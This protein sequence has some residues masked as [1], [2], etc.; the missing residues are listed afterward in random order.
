M[1]LTERL[2]LIVSLDA[3]GAVQGLS[4]VGNAAEKELGKTENRL[5]RVGKSMSKTGVVML[6]AGAV[7]GGAL[8]KA[9]LA[10]ERAEASTRKLQNS[11][12]NSAQLAGHS[13]DEF[14]D[15]AAAIQKKTAAD[16]DDIVAGQAILAQ[17]KLEADEIKTLTPLVVDLARKK[18]IDLTAASTAVAKAMA[19]QSGALKKAGVIVDE[20]A[21][22]TDRFTAI[23]TAL[24]DSVGGFAEEEGKTFAGSLERLKNQ[25]EDISEGV[26]KGAVDAFSSMLRPVQGLS[27][28]FAGLDPKVQS[29]VGKIGT[30]G[31]AGLIVVGAT[32][33]IVG[34]VLTL[35]QSFADLADKAPRTASALSAVGKAAAIAG[36]AFLGLQIIEVARSFNKA[37]IDANAFSAA[38]NKA[39]AAQR[40]QLESS[41]LAADRFN[42]LNDLV[43]QAADQNVK[44]AQG[45]VDVAKAAGLSGERIKE[46]QG[47]VDDKRAADV[48][49]SKD[50][51]A[52]GEEVSTAADS[53]DDLTAALVEEEAAMQAVL[54]ATLAQFDSNLGYRNSVD[55]VEDK[56]AD[57]ATMHREGKSTAEEYDDANRNLEGSLLSQAAAAV[58]AAEDQAIAAGK[59]LTASEKAGIYRGELELLKAKFPELAAL[60][61]GYIDKLNN[62]PASKTTYLYLESSSKGSFGRPIFEKPPGKALGGPVKKGQPYIVGEN[63]PELFVPDQNGT[64]IP[65]VPLVAASAQGYAGQTHNHYIT[66]RTEVGQVVAQDYNDFVR[67]MNERQ[68][69]D[70]LAGM[71]EHG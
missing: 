48:Q 7:I 57:L 67:Q 15:L 32:G 26:G 70:A 30:F 59:T 46:L 44:A 54:S 1:A 56:I 52:Y 43:E 40:K 53:V 61:Q 51:K 39:D 18:G 42:K 35:R 34:K 37:T 71:G 29:S 41:V 58:R 45:L 47:I 33:A 24:K 62:I 50:Q 9:A 64:I 66:N 27:E 17:F 36:A 60:I 3:K 28:A 2:A 20:T 49:G 65:S 63:R 16:A 25:L 69:F 23:T 10:S 4:N 13:A 38:L 31:A 19:G 12:N 68:R 22:K 11:I 21:F 55:E 5:D 8:V 6:G 14:T